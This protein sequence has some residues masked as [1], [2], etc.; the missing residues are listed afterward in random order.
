MDA[1]FVVQHAYERDESEEIKFIG[2]YSTRVKA[3]AAVLRLK[4]QP[5]FRE[6][7]DDFHIERYEIDRDHWEEGFVTERHG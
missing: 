7:P 6:H 4:E 2:V 1:V 5:G 3:E